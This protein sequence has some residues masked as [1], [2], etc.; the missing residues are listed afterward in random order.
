LSRETKCRAADTYLK[1]DLVWR[2]EGSVR[3]A[4]YP[5]HISKCT[6]TLCWQRAGAQ[7]G[8]SGPGFLVAGV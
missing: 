6:E 1:G 7:W 3:T 8:R 4:S 2:I 5:H